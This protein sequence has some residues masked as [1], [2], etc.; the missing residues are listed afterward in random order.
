[1]N[2]FFALTLG[3]LSAL[4]MT[5]C[6]KPTT[7][8]PY[9]A[10]GKSELDRLQRQINDRPDLETAEQELTGLDAQIRAVIA[11]HSPATQ[12]VPA[13]AVVSGCTDPFAH[14]IGRVYGMA[15]S[16]G[17][18]P[19]RDG[20]WS[21]ISAELKPILAAAGFRPNTPPGHPQ[22]GGNLSVIRADGTLIDLTNSPGALAYRFTSGCRLPAAWRAGPPP[23]GDR[24]TNDA[25]V[26]Y[27][28]LYGSPGGR[29]APPT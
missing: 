7:F 1:M 2:K 29:S 14:N 20:D 18:P 22:P 6:V 19:P 17:D 27:P 28:Y 5:A 25:D 10:P 9:A 15:N 8:N 4:A 16:Y 21:D 3:L 24:P 13:P 12:I 26:S 11:K 23:P